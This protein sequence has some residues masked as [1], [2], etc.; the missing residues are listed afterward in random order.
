MNINVNAT[1]F[2]NRANAHR[3]ILQL[4]W[5]FMKKSDPEIAENIKNTCMT[6]AKEL[7]KIQ[8]ENLFSSEMQSIFED[9]DDTGK[10]YLSIIQGGKI[11]K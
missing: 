5:N 11:D 2:G 6:A 10:P 7:E 8:P 1:E 4:L 3:M 9:F